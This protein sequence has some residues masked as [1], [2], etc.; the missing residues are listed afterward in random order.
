MISSPLFC[1]PHGAVS[2]Q[3]RLGIILSAPSTNLGFLLA[4]ISKFKLEEYITAKIVVCP[5]NIDSLGGHEA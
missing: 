5:L 2:Q 4:K 3:N 1:N